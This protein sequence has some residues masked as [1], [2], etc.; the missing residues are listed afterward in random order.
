MTGD[1]SPGGKLNYLWL[2]KVD[3]CDKCPLW[4]DRNRIV[5]GEGN[6]S[7]DIMFVGE[8]PGYDEDRTGRPFVGRA[9]KLL[10][11]LIE[12]IG[13]SRSEVYIGNIIKCRPPEN[14]D[15]TEQEIE[16]CFRYL[17]VQIHIIQPRLIVALGRVAGNILSKQPYPLRMMDLRDDAWR[18]EDEKTGVLVP[19][20]SVYHPAYVLR[21]GPKLERSEAYR[22]VLED[23]KEGLHLMESRKIPPGPARHEEP[24]EAEPVEELVDM[25]QGDEG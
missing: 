16:G 5:F 17:R 10:D 15:P 6:P 12:D 11:R 20:V 22:R 24:V 3:E 8:A 2:K 9:G 1:E 23:L 13:L 14:R 18:Y 25:L 7:A 19:L 4:F 21:Q